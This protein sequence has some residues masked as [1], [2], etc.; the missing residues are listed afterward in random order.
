MMNLHATSL[1]A[2]LVTAVIL[3]VGDTYP[4]GNY[5]LASHCEFNPGALVNKGRHDPCVSLSYNQC[6]K[7]MECWWR[8][9]TAQNALWNHTLETNLGQVLVP[10]TSDQVTVYVYNSKNQ[11]ANSIAI[12]SG[13]I[14]MLVGCGGSTA[15]ATEARAA[16]I[17]AIPNVLNL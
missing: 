12:V 13:T 9:T 8:D 1:L 17:N 2:L 10:Y 11:I 6:N 7:R 14:W 5:Y 4:S 15:A 3:V 16:F